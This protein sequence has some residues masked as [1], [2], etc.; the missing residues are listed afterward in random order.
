MKKKLIIVTILIL[1]LL[2]GCNQRN[3][4]VQDTNNEKWN[5]EFYDCGISINDQITNDFKVVG[6]VIY[7]SAIDWGK[8]GRN[9]LSI[10]RGNAFTSGLFEDTGVSMS[11]RSEASWTVRLPLESE[12]STLFL[13]DDDHEYK[14]TI[15]ENKNNGA[16]EDFMVIS[17]ECIPESSITDFTIS[18][19]GKV[20]LLTDQAIY[21]FCVKNDSVAEFPMMYE[22]PKESRVFRIFS[23]ADKFYCLARKVKDSGSNNFGIY[24]YGEDGNIEKTIDI[25]INST[26]ITPLDTEIAFYIEDQGIFYVDPLLNS[27]EMV[28]DLSKED[29]TWSN[30]TAVMKDNNRY[31]ILCQSNSDMVYRTIAFEKN[32]DKKDDVIEITLCDPSGYYESHCPQKI[33][34]S[35]NETHPGYHV[36]VMN[37]QKDLNYILA[38]SEQPDLI[39]LNDDDMC[40]LGK[41]GY[42]EDLGNYIESDSTKI[43]EEITE[44]LLDKILIENATFG[45]PSKFSISTFCAK[46][47]TLNEKVGWTIDEFLDW[48][49]DRPEILM[50]SG[51]NRSFLLQSVLDGGMD[52]YIDFANRKCDFDGEKFIRHLE[53]MGRLKENT[54]EGWLSSETGELRYRTIFFLRT[55]LLMED[56]ED[57]WVY[58]GLPTFDGRELH[59][60]NFNAMS[61][62]KTSK[63]KEAA[64]EFLKY[65]VRYRYWD[66]YCFGSNYPVFQ[67]VTEIEKKMYLDSEFRSERVAVGQKEIDTLMRIYK[68][69]EMYKFD[70]WDIE[71]IVLEEAETYLSGDKE[72][73]EVT[74][75]IQNRVQLVLDEA[76]K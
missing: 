66:N 64:F 43:K 59:R 30:V 16:L 22:I 20:L 17:R 55:L 18:R 67:K 13:L 44:G 1:C 75:H 74:D 31:A 23:M 26:A 51:L 29:K 34:D 35:F 19:D 61:I 37:T 25:P 3:Q 33:I 38:S 47:S 41:S 4:N 58:K 5:K 60:L 24:L 36:S 40:L 71:R 46:S 11:H 68:K 27:Y 9:N 42:L 15:K 65:F 72:L 32:I 52:D 70:N 53:I 14:I 6:D 76:T 50:D 28:V 21:G 7:F 45:M 39:L 73:E 56:P 63:N 69:S 49:S 54:Q 62:L 57:P 12:S 8:D 48:M 2:C 10:Y